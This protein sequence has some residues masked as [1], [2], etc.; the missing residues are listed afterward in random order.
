MSIATLDNLFA[1]SQP[2][3]Q[4]IKSSFTG[5]A[6]GVMHS[7][8][9]LTGM[10][11][12]MAV[13]S[14]G[15]NG[16][17]ITAAPV[18][19]QGALDFT[20]P[21]GGLEQLLQTLSMAQNGNIGGLLLY[22][23]IWHNSGIVPGTTTAQAI[24]FP[25][26]APTRD[27]NGAALGDGWLAAIELSTASTNGAPITNTVITY[28]NSAGVGSRTGTIASFPANAVAGTFVPFMLQAGDTG[29]QSI[30]SIT[31]GTSY[32]TAVM[33]L[34]MYRPIV[35]TPTREPG[36][37]ITQDAAGD[38]GKMKLFDGSALFLAALLTGTAVGAN[39][40]SVYGQW[41]TSV[42]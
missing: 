6:A 18:A 32:G 22:D 1:G 7:L 3:R 15:I 42:G 17:Y 38:F 11:G 26:S 25:G 31:L 35:T 37:L 12:A 8:A 33:S 29:I 2:Q 36:A 24:A 27:R 9:Y 39:G 40:V 34:V 21:G 23:R 13:P 14:M 30:Q 16:A 28:T 5:Q 10:P 19:F 41:G 20:N 4:I